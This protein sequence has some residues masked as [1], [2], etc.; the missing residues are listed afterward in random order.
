MHF[1]GSRI[2]KNDAEKVN[3]NLLAVLDKFGGQALWTKVSLEM[4]RSSGFTP[5]FIWHHQPPEEINAK[6]QMLGLALVLIQACA[7]SAI[8]SMF[9]FVLHV[10]TSHGT[11]L[12]SLTIPDLFI[13]RLINLLLPQMEFYI[14]IYIYIDFKTRLIIICM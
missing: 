13:S 9:Y 11:V 8:I 14:Y 1:G 3:L 10:Y 5:R 12:L 2:K 6:A 7:I 4:F